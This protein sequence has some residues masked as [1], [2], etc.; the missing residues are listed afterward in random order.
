MSALS[1]IVAHADTRLFNQIVGNPKL[2]SAPLIPPSKSHPYNL[3][4]CRHNMQIPPAQTNSDKNFITR[5]ILDLNS[6][7]TQ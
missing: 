6:T 2:V 7:Q 3:W 4:N 1:E 5:I